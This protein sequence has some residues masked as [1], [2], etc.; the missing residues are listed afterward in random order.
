MTIST[1]ST[2][3]E[4]V[5]QDYRTASVFQ[6]YRIDFCCQGNRTIGDVCKKEQI[7]EGLLTAALEKAIE[8]TAPATANFKEWPLQ[9][10]AD[11]I[12]RKHHRYVKTKIKEIRPLLRKIVTVH[13][14]KHPELAEVETLF[15]QSATEMLD[16]M[17]KEEQE[18]FPYIR[19]IAKAKELDK[20]PAFTT[21]SIGENAI[22]L[23]HHEHAAE[24]DRF[25]Q[26]ALLT[27]DYT[28]PKDGC[29]TYAAT[30]LLLKEFAQDLHL[31]IHLENNILFPRTIQLEKK[32]EAY[33]KN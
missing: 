18:L 7:N 20:K 21:N 22:L 9:L 8:T 1:K 15:H 19:K 16:H 17:K 11:Y 28:L 3:G 13:G 6:S 4:L 31:H 12:E 25:R 32:D 10:L 27:E 14:S 5:A 26:I 29:I 33:Y 2:I 24:G 23:L 30:L